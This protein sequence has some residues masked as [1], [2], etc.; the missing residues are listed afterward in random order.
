MPETLKGMST[1]PIQN[2]IFEDHVQLVI[3]LGEGF[4]LKLIGIS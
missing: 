1:Q 4:F 2:C 3:H